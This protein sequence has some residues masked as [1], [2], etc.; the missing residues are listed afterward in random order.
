MKIL[1]AGRRRVR[2]ADIHQV[3]LPGHA[4]NVLNVRGARNHALG[5]QKA[6]AQL[7]IGA[8][9]SHDDGEGFAAHL[10][11][12]WLFGRDGVHRG[13]WVVGPH[14]EHG[15]PADDAGG[16]H[17]VEPVAIACVRHICNGRP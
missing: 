6:D 9:R 2:D 12:Q 13:R 10:H 7:A 1:Q 15:H 5:Q 3:A 4:A 14:L 8:R 17:G 16:H 11:L